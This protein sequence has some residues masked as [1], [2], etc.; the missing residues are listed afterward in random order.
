MR[1]AFALLI[2]LCLIL[3]GRVFAAEKLIVTEIK[4][5]RAVYE[6]KKVSDVGQ[7]QHEV[8]LKWT[9]TVKIPYN[10]GAMDYL[11]NSEVKIY[12]LD[13]PDAVNPG[14]PVATLD[15]S[16]LYTMEEIKKTGTKDSSGNIT[17]D[18]EM[19]YTDS[20]DRG[21]TYYYYRVW[22]GPGMAGDPTK[23][24][25]VYT[26]KQQGQ[27]VTDDKRKKF[28]E[29]EDW[30]SRLAGSVLMSIPNFI[31]K[32][33]GLED[34]MELIYQTKI[35]YVSNSGEPGRPEGF[36][37]PKIVLEGDKSYFRTFTASEFGGIAKFYERVN[38]VVPVSLV[39]L[40]VLMGMGFLYTSANPNSKITFKEYVI[41]LLLGA[42]A[43]KFGIYVLQIVFDIN[44]AIVKYFEYIAGDRL[45]DSFL[46][47]IL[48]DESGLGAAILFFVVVFSVA[49]INWQYIIRKIVIALLIGLLPLV[50][51]I[52]ILPSRR[53]ALAYWAKE[54][55]S[56]VFLQS[57]HAAVL[58]LA[59]LLMAPDPVS[60]VAMA[61]MGIWMKVAC[62][63]GLPTIAP[64]VRRVI[65]ADDPGGGMMT[66]IGALIGAGSLANIGKMLTVQKKKVP[67]VPAEAPSPGSIAAGSAAGALSGGGGIAGSVLGAGLRMGAGAVAGLAGGFLAGPVG[68]MTGAKIGS[69]IADRVSDFAGG[70]VDFALSS[71]EQRLQK[72]GL[73]HSAQLDD[74]KEAYQAG[75]R[76]FG[77]GVTGKAL[78]GGMALYKFAQ[79]KLGLTDPGAVRQVKQGISSDMAALN[80]ARQQVA[81]HKP[82]LDEARAR[83][84]HAKSAS[85]V[86]AGNIK[87]LKRQEESL[88][89]RENI[90][91][92]EFCAASDHYDSSRWWDRGAIEDMKQKSLDLY[93]AQDDVINVR[94][95]IEGQEKALESAR[96]EQD[97]AELA[98]REAEI[99]HARHQVNVSGLEQKLSTE[100]IRQEFEKIKTG[101]EYKG[102][103]SSSW[104]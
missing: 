92:Q 24:V 94:S 78:G 39:L 48:Q 46:S 47:T 58:T 13:T 70:A 8:K 16:R 90:A 5:V 91:E 57:A 43:L 12:R 30:P 83:F 53:Y 42:A 72:M 88:I 62:I 82:V 69:G 52:S 14:S 61:D 36:S 22:S 9:A 98:L 101:N 95:Q 10:P 6:E 67:G 73:F 7:V 77:D 25:R 4:N 71:P 102:G 41:G 99:I 100:R 45:R 63:A 51:V 21:N 49:V 104:R 18:V 40:I 84:G 81:A 32:A 23:D 93:Y 64:L 2:L 86:A 37:T 66:S 87:E 17:A 27:S 3:P 33:I 96:I 15:V 80:A 11:R 65:G 29:S 50:A 89:V 75:Q 19:E 55:F 56:Q 79:G 44:Y 20:P 38:E 97:R 34:P 26:G 85:A 76:L 54:F 1:K 35:E 28:A 31:L 68:M 59:L 74:P 103:I 60:N